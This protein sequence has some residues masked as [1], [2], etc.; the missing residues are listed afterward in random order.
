MVLDEKNKNPVKLVIAG[1][2]DHGKSTLVGRLLHDSNL[3][4]DGKMKSIQEMSE[5]RGM[6]LEYAFLK[7]RFKQSGTKALQSM[8][9][10]FRSNLPKELTGL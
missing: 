7:T 8:L 9:H 10:K 5:R 2:V 4:P 3:L 1:H 6:Q